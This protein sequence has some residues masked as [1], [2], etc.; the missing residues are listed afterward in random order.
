MNIFFKQAGRK[1]AFTL[2]MV[3][4][5]S[6]SIALSCVGYSAWTSV[7]IQKEEISN[8]YTT[9]AVLRTPRTPATKEEE[10]EWGDAAVQS[11]RVVLADLAAQKAPQLAM[12]DRRCLLSAHIAGSKSLSSSSVDPGEYNVAFDGECYSLAVFALRCESVLEK[13]LEG[14]KWYDAA[15]R[16][17]EIVSLSAGYDTLPEPDSVR[18]VT[19]FCEENGDVPF[20]EGKTYLVFG[21]YQDR[22]VVKTVAGFKQNPEHLRYIIPFP[23]MVSNLGWEVPSHQDGEQNGITYWYPTPGLLPWVCEYTGTVAEYLSSDAGTVWR[24]EILPICQ[25]NQESAAVILT[26]SIESMYSFN[27]GNNELLSGRFFTEEEYAEGADVCVVSAAYAELND[28]QLG[29]TIRLDYYNSGHI[30]YT[31]GARANTE[32][33]APDP[34]PYRQRKYMTPD[35]A[36]DVCKEYTI[37]GLYTGARFGFG[38]HHVNGDTIFVP[39]ASVPHAEDYESPANSLLNTFVLKNG[40]A[41]EFEQYMEQQELGGQFLYF[42]QEFDS[43]QE[44]LDAL[45]TNAMRLMMVGVGVLVLACALFLFLNFRRMKATIQGARLLGRSSKA[46]FTEMTVVLMSL[47]LL[48]AVIGTGIAAVLFDTVTEKVLSTTLALRPEAMVTACA[49]A[50][51]FL[52]IASMIGAGIFA[53]RKLMKAK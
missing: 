51:A 11:Q 25:I 9:I 12:I 30:E 7:K 21:Q 31:N 14:L 1:P 18:I 39:K 46:V 41:E 50:F 52:A 43:M 29:D 8:G 2:L 6:F 26:D 34:G 32:F 20:E 37:V 40:T 44:S 38:G 16:V 22:P 10:A 48:A 45:E 33:I 5:L 15:F 42:D 19:N 17:E 28:L 49:A 47:E 24:E 3:L 23:E 27:T 13:P 53:R 35:D 4:L 36:I